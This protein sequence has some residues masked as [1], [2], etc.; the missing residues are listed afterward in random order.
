[1][2]LVRL[3]LDVRGLGAH[4]V[5]KQRCT[6]STQGCIVQS[7]G[8]AM[9]DRSPGYSYRAALRTALRWAPF[10]QSS[11]APATVRFA[12]RPP[13]GGPGGALCNPR[14]NATSKKD[15]TMKTGLMAA[16][17]ACW[18]KALASGRACL[19]SKGTPHRLFRAAA[20]IALAIVIVPAT[21]LLGGAAFADGGAAAR[22][23][24]RKLARGKG[25]AP[26]DTGYPTGIQAACMPGGTI[27]RPGRRESRAAALMGRRTCAQTMAP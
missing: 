12:S 1:M 14:G 25:A 15:E 11:A 20:A 16:A 10:E 26:Q 18:R 23:V 22:W 6:C 9:R 8:L 17:A 27:H 7:A 21:V 19:E 4:G 5:W 13:W 2:C 24:P 3:T